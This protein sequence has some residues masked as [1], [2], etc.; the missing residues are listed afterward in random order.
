MKF[1][2]SF[3]VVSF[4]TFML[5]GCSNNLEVQSETK[6]FENGASTAAEE[7]MLSALAKT[8]NK[9]KEIEEATTEI[10]IAEQVVKATIVFKKGTTDEKKSE[11]ANAAMEELTEKFPNYQPNVL[12]K[13][14]E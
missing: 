3:L 2:T 4:A 7:E 12:S 1:K 10:L 5:V 11:I 9:Y 8:L 14:A 6:V 13:D